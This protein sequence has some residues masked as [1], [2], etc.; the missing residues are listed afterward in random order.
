MKPIQECSKWRESILAAAGEGRAGEPDTPIQTHLAACPQCRR[1]AEGLRAAAAGLRWLADRPVVP[2]PG[3][4]ARWTQAVEEA[5]QPAGLGEI[6]AA[7]AAW[8]HQLLL[9]NLRPAMGMASLWALALLF[10]LTAPDTAP[11][12]N[13]TAASSPLAIYRALRA[14]HQ[15]LAEAPDSSVPAPVVPRS[16]RLPHPRSQALPAEPSAQLPR[17]HPVV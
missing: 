11:A 7:L 12:A 5:A 3:L 6:L 16:S 2:S 4:R 17:S 10:R 8:A 13:T 1:Y 15:L 9:C 14:S